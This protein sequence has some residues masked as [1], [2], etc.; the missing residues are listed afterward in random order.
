MQEA[1][2]IG[3]ETI[4]CHTVPAGLHR[5]TRTT[6]PYIDVD[7]IDKL[8]I[9]A[10]MGQHVQPPAIR[11][12]LKDAGTFCAGEMHGLSSDDLENF[13]KIQRRGDD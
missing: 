11:V 5:T 8:G 10:I 1:V 2:F 3:M 7:A 9:H 12:Q 13:V 4:N 6:L